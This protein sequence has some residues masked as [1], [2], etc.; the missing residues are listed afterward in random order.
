MFHDQNSA[1]I[2]MAHSTGAVYANFNVQSWGKSHMQN[3]E[4]NNEEGGGLEPVRKVRDDAIHVER[5]HR[6]PVADVAAV[7]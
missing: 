6:L 7:S 2:M 3:N 5:P 1:V 4:E